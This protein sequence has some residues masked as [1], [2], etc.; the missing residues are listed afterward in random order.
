MVSVSVSVCN[1]CC[2]HLSL[3]LR[4]RAYLSLACMLWL[5][6]ASYWLE[7]VATSRLTKT[8]AQDGCSHM[9][10]ASY[11]ALAVASG[12]RKRAALGKLHLAI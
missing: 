8:I 5:G 9:E 10:R 12:K 1:T 3:Y 4:L 6:S 2:P 7:F 11:H